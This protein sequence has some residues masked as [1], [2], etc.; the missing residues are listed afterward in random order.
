[1][2]LGDFA[3]TPKK[4]DKKAVS[5]DFEFMEI[6]ADYRQIGAVNYT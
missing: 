1:M 2:R 5:A 4:T 6:E 3:K